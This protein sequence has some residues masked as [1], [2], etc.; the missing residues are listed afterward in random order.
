MSFCF[1]PGVEA[2][3]DQLNKT[4]EKL[5]PGDRMDFR[6]LEGFRSVLLGLFIPC[7]LPHGETILNGYFFQAES[8]LQSLVELVSD[9]KSASLMAFNCTD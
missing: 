1:P 5:A 6:W 7:C 3:E 9:A 8:T 4:I 2:D